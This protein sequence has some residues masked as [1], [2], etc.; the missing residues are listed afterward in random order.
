M[1]WMT[2]RGARPARPR[3]RPAD[4]R[5]AART[6]ARRRARAG[7]LLLRPAGRPGPAG[8]GALRGRKPRILDGSERRPAARRRPHRHHRAGRPGAHQPGRQGA[9]RRPGRRPRPRAGRPRAALGRRP[10][11]RRH[12]HG[13]ARFRRGPARSR[14]SFVAGTSAFRVAPQVGAGRLQLVA[15][16]AIETERYVVHVFE[17]K[18]QQ[19]LTL[20]AD[21]TSYLHGQPLVVDAVL[22]DSNARLRFDQVEAYVSAPGGRAWPLPGDPPEGRQLPR[23]HR[24][25]RPGSHARGPVGS[26]L[27]GPRPLGRRPRRGARRPHRLRLRLADRRLRRPGRHP[28]RRQIGRGGAAAPGRHRRPLRSARRPLRHQ[29]RRRAAADGD[30]PLRELAR[31]RPRQPRPHLRQ[32]RRR[33]KAPT[34]CATCASTTRAAWASCIA[35]TR[36]WSFP[37]PAFPIFSIRAERPGHPGLACI[38]AYARARYLSA[39]RSNDHADDDQAE[40]SQRG[41]GAGP[42]ARHFPRRHPRLSALPRRPEVQAQAPVRPRRGGA[43]RRRSLALRLLLRERPAEPPARGGSGRRAGGSGGT[44]RARHRSRS[45]RPE[46]TLPQQD[47]QHRC[48]GRQQQLP[49]R[50]HS[51]QDCCRR[52]QL[53]PPLQEDLD[54]GL[55]QQPAPPPPPPLLLQHCRVPLGTGPPL[56]QTGCISLRRLAAAATAAR[57][58]RRPRRRCTRRFPLSWVIVPADPS[59]P[60]QLADWDCPG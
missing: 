15:P 22:G 29:R 24:A 7:R 54:C 26:E 38:A 12:R 39:H 42:R 33:L 25:R 46:S 43:A 56:L 11:R 21:K 55:R 13:A 14:R 19:K 35:R 10:L 27:G 18:S 17:P 3:R 36:R 48:L 44:R 45:R 6:L 50:L 60:R 40:P 47:W 59:P 31:S 8:A 52:Q 16:L 1:E 5:A 37:D 9:G 28:P 2:L 32:P 30:L 34:R 23:R 49:W 20:G 57:Q 4:R 41:D 53:Q 58:P 51:W